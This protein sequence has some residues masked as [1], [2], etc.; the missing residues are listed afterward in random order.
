M[1][2]SH[3]IEIVQERLHRLEERSRDLS[4]TINENNHQR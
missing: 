4:G 1:F 3:S 2:I